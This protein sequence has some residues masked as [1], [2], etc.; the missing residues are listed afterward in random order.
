MDGQGLA[1]VLTWTSRRSV[2][3]ICNL[4]FTYFFDIIFIE[5][6]EKEKNYVH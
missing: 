5:K 1:Y 2:H 6:K 3:S 4:I